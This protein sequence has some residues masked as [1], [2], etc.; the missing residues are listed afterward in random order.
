MSSKKLK[1]QV[2]SD[3]HIELWNKLPE[4]PIKSKYLFLAG[5]I[6]KLR[7]PLFYKFFDYCSERWEKVFYVPG[8]HEF[9][10]NRKNYNELDFEYNHNLSQ[11]YK[12]IY[13]LNNNSAPLDESI[14]V[15]GSIFWTNPMFESTY[16]AKTLIND[17]NSISYFNKSA[18][19]L[20]DWNL[21]YVREISNQSYALLHKHLNETNKKTIVVTHF[22]PFRTGSSNPKYDND[23]P[24]IK[25]Y[26]SWPDEMLKNIKLNNV[27]LWISGHTHWSYDYEKFGK[28]FISNQ[29][30]YRSEVG[31][32]GI[33]EE[34][35]F[36]VEITS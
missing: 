9:Y 25:S 33:N 14:N 18:R 26:F 2:F 32:T 15:Y 22:P 5:D 24:I 20:E 12:N 21:N 17:Y 11:R 7:H 29:L 1:V 3:I 23:N 31:K 10:D 4:L 36:E 30:G 13:Y 8:N 34:G 28:R 16:Q 27:P 19:Q 6:C 35:L